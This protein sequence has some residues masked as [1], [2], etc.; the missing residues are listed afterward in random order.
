MITFLHPKPADSSIWVYQM[1]HFSAWFRVVA[2]DLPG[3]GRS[4]GISASATMRDIASACWDTLA[5]AGIKR[6][7]LVG[8]SVG[9]TVAQYM[10]A[11]RPSSTPG[12]ILTG[13]GYFARSDSRFRS[14]V[15]ASIEDYRERGSKAQAPQLGRGFSQKYAASALADY[16]AAILADRRDW[17][18]TETVLRLYALL[19][20]HPVPDW[21]L[22]RIRAP[23]LIISGRQ[24]PGHLAHREL[25]RR[26]RGS[27]FE[28]IVEAGHLCNVEAPWD[29][30]RFVLEFLRRHRLVPRPAGTHT[31]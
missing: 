1:A 4:Q 8:L 16:F 15:Q 7:I 3:Y 5:E 12:L 29:Y 23:T 13:G 20:E 18:D 28:V 2:V 9:S 19:L 11:Q 27:E 17:L 22:D 31:D 26:V 10:A 30:D 24:D 6:S 25:A 21:V 14:V